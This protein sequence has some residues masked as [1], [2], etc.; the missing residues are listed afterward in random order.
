VYFLANDAIFDA[1]VAF[2]NSL[3]AHN[4]DI[5]LCL[6]PFADDVTRLTALRDR[7]RFD[8]WS[9]QSLLRACDDISA[10]FH[11]RTVGQYRKLALW[12]GRF[13]EFVYVDSDTVVL[14][15]LDFVYPYLAEH[16]FVTSHSNIAELRRWVWHD[17]IEATGAL[18]P[19]QYDFAASTGFVASRRGC[20]PFAEVAA[21]VPAALDLAE[22]MELVCCEQ[23]L[24]NYLMV[25]SGRPY[26]SLHAIAAATGDATIPMERWAGEPLGPV[27][28]GQVVQR[29]GKPPILLAHWAGEWVRAAMTGRP[30]PNHALWSHY[31]ALTPATV[32]GGVAGVGATPTG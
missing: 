19:A 5:A 7:Y 13:D 16:A 2:L 10:G 22:H 27:V 24:L 26:T 32:V 28:G 14:H 30:I 8:I 3:R 15:S 18:D 25:T 9:D 21:K 20:L 23:P 4:P 12:E 17:S 31:R 1:A 11:G 6:V 29:A